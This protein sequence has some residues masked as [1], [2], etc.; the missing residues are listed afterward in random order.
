VQVGKLV[1]DLGLVRS[2][3]EPECPC[4]LSFVSLSPSHIFLHLT[5]T[6]S[7][8]LSRLPSPLLASRPTSFLLSLPL[9]H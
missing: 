7:L 9:A 8:S 4:T 2:R 1:A 6:R 5:H 3:G